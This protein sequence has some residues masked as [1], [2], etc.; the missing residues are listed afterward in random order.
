MITDE[1]RW[2]V[3]SLRILQ[4]KQKSELVVHNNSNVLHLNSADKLVRTPLWL[5]FEQIRRILNQTHSLYSQS[6]LQYTTQS[7][8]QGSQ[9]YHSQ[10][11]SGYDLV[12]ILRYLSYKIQL[13]LELKVH[14]KY[15]RQYQSRYISVC[16]LMYLF[17]KIQ[18][19]VI[20]NVYLSFKKVIQ[21]A[22]C[23]LSKKQLLSHH[24][25]SG[26]LFQL[27]YIWVL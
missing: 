12:C 18:L 6:I 1:A 24:N 8:S 5:F 13:N 19:K 17:Y 27:R 16:I 14:L 7:R 23:L 20:P 22:S 2:Y 26:V 21:N 4:V 15:H 9:E 3:N 25:Q 10:Y 11:L